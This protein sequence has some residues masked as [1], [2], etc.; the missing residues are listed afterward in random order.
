MT[1]VRR[2]ERAEVIESD[3]CIIGSGITAAMV[4][5]KLAEEREARDRRRGGRRRHGAAG[6]ARRRIA[7][8]S[9]RYGENP[10]G[11]DHLDG[12]TA[13]GHPVALDAGRRARDALGRRDAALLARGLSAAK[14]LFG[15]GHGLADLVRRSRAVLSRSGRAD[16]R[17][18]RAGSAGARSA[19]QAVP[20]A[21]APADVQ[22]RAAQ[23]VGGDSAGIAMW[24]QPSAKNSVAYR[25]RAGV[26]SQR[27]VRAGVSGR[28]EVFAGLHV[29]RAARDEAGWSSCRARSSGGSCWTRWIEPDRERG[30]RRRRPRHRTARA[31]ISVRRTF[32]VAAGYA[33]SPHLLLLSAQWAR[34]ERH[35]EPVGTGR[36]IPDGHRNVSAFVNFRCGSIRA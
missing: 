20:D 11:R 14:S 29:E 3:I 15:V 2:Q 25:G 31:W 28:R 5:E 4:A 16:R 1:L 9:S 35:R 18:G 23:A 6:R 30:G 7:R 32:V 17:R 22:P 27:Y 19:R 21:A 33:W 13:D 36:Q 8:G 26:L 34:P 10:W 24:S 12:M